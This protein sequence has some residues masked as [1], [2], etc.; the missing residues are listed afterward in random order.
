[1]DGRTSF[2]SRNGLA[3]RTRRHR[4]SH[5]GSATRSRRSRVLISRQ[6]CVRVSKVTLYA[7]THIAW[8]PFGA[9]PSS[10][11]LEGVEI[12]TAERRNAAP[13]RT[14]RRR[15]APGRRATGSRGSS[16]SHCST[17]RRPITLSAHPR[18]STGSFRPSSK[19]FHAATR[20][21]AILQEIARSVYQNFR[22]LARPFKAAS[23]LCA[24]NTRSNGPD[25]ARPLPTRNCSVPSPSYR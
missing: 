13:P 3:V 4:R 5:P 8:T 25:R 7:G 10:A 19:G 15:R 17:A 11:T 24:E 16:C 22:A 21:R 9:I 14:V 6:A 20:K 12:E 23:T 1:M 18:F 2:A